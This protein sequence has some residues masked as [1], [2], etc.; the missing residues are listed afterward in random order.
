[1]KVIFL[2]H[3]SYYTVK[4]LADAIK[5]NTEE[6]SISVADLVKPDGS[7]IS[8]D[9]LKTFDRVINLPKK[10]DTKFYVRDRIKATM[11]GLSDKEKRK[12][13]LK[14]LVFL[15]IRSLLN[16]IS[17]ET[18]ERVYGIKMK[19]L[20]DDFD[21]FHFH[22]VSP[23]YLTLLKY[24]SKDKK[25]IFSFWGSDLFQQAGLE[26]YKIQ[27]RGLERAD[28]ITLNTP[29]MQEAFLTKFGRNFINKIR[30]AYFIL[31]ELKFEQINSINS[32][33]VISEFK[34]KNKIPLYK[35][36]VTI[37]YNA[38][39]KQ[40]HIEILKI[41]AELKPE[42]KEKIHIVIPLSYG[43]QYESK[44]YPDEIEKI[45]CKIGIGTTLVYKYQETK[46]LA[47]FT[48]ASEIKLNVRETD[49]LN[50]SLIESLA[51]GNIVVNG[52]W[53]PYGKLRRLGIYYREIEKLEDL[54]NIIP[55][56]L[57]NFEDEKL[58][59]R[60]NYKIIREFFSVKNLV[61]DWTGLYDEIKINSK[62]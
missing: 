54:L 3:C 40:R 8:A 57:E 36:I 58:K 20:F 26:N 2:G 50:A 7:E 47:E 19:D 25:I 33:R 6:I 59:V 9:E 37:G 61:K 56:I 22:Y 60:N 16:F 48:I 21:V 10:R 17:S 55:D 42:V 18:E 49:C 53:L 35:K 28:Y 12:L 52:A 29:E 30:T 32:E 46:E 27:Y 43:L 14:P 41:L 31:N 13:F 24:I 39:S 23:E 34:N 15:K 45:V 38:S 51:A 44:N 62:K 5:K 1:M 11:N 4:N